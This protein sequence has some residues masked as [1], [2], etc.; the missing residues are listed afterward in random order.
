MIGWIKRL[1]GA[2]AAA[3]V[4]VAAAG[5][6]M[7]RAATPAAT[8]SPV[9]RP[10]AAKPVATVSGA[11]GVYGVQ[12]PLVGRLG[13]VAGFECALPPHIA[14]R[15]AARGDDGTAAAAHHTL[16][17]QQLRP[18]LDAGR[19]AVLS[20][21]AALLARPAVAEAVPSQAWLCVSGLPQLPPA[22]AQAL[23]Q[24]GVRLGVPDGPPADAPAA[25]F[26]WLQGHDTDAVLLAAER[27]R[28]ARP[29]LPLMVTGLGAVEDV[30][31]LLQAGV[32]LAGGQLQRRRSALDRPLNA[33]AHR[34]CELMNHLALDRDTATV[35]DAVRADVALTYRLLTYANSP[36]LGLAQ[37]SGRS[38]DSVE[39]ALA[40]LGRRELTRWLQVLLLS[41]AASRQ[42][43]VAL[44]EQALARGRLLEQLA[45]ADD[46]ADAPAL[47][48]VGL[49]SMLETLL[50][51]PLA[52]A[53]AP[54]R[55][56]EE[57]CAALLQGQGPWA[58]YLQLAAALDG[59]DAAAA[60]TL[61][62][63]WGG[64][65]RV[66]PWADEAWAWAGQVV[67]G[68]NPPAQGGT[69]R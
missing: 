17:L 61:A 68:T 40:L 50:E 32:D 63:R 2:D 54:L 58:P 56:R 23:R 33:A 30:E 6:T 37:R 15:L 48:S 13:R 5:A 45:R 64:M 46:V 44:Q 1:V 60:E 62:A 52:Q 25:D 9:T 35:A 21:P 14:H 38:I 59:G 66:Q 67:V 10:A 7:A 19:L 12:R 28:E 42:A 31:R 29:Q 69:A 27:W 8:A 20:L 36:A 43:G 11:A 16:L 57:A 26:A 65:P 24:R 18:L 34:I 22:L 51:L 47:F 55:L 49:F 41:S 39:Q 4:A 53:L 3:P